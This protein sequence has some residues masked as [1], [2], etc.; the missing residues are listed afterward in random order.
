MGI[1]AACVLAAG[2][3]TRMHSAKPKVLQTVLGEPMVR[4][5]LHALEE[6][7]AGNIWLVTGHGADAV[8]NSVLSFAPDAHFVLQ[9]E[10]LGTGHALACAL[11]ALK[12]AGVERV[13]VINGDIPL[14]DR[15]VLADFL[16]GTDGTDLAF[17]T[18][19]LPDPGAYGRVV[20]ADG[21]LLGIVEAKDYELSK[22]G[23]PS[24]E[25][26]AGLYSLTLDLCE[27]LLPLVGNAN[28]SGEYY[29]TDL[30]GLALERGY[31][32]KG[33]VCGNNTALLGVNSPLELAGAEAILQKSVNS[34]LLASG[35]ILHAPETVRISPFADIEPGADITGPCEIT[36]RS[37]V[38]ADAR[39][40]TSCVVRDSVVES[41]AEIRPFSHLENAVVHAEAL[42]GPYARLRPGAEL[43]CRS[44]VGNFVELKKTQLGEGAKANHLTY[45]GDAVIG[46]GTNI[47]AG[48]ITCN[49]D[50]KHK[51]QTRI[52]ANAFIGS[53]TAMVAPVRIGD[54]ALIGAGSVI[55]RDVPDNELS[56]ARARQKNLGP[57]CELGTGSE[58]K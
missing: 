35:V 22:Y 5:V 30:V 34:A 23:T 27:E 43:G 51:F 40:M 41:G 46:S 28:R 6:H 18:I 55:T 42:V 3:G 47:G 17:A 11:P 12:E 36:G 25:V 4:Y 8:R 56:I 50:G 58:K 16:A 37:R 15:R 38:C 54:N 57:K 31:R 26:N 29:I 24:G 32:V 1:Q 33:V 9:S 39:I 49:Y 52:G 2:K 19:T 13:L 10:Q 7:F 45:L 20:R 21:R 14:V 53:N 44:H 48:T